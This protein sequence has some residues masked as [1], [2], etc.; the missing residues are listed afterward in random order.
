MRQL[1]PVDPDFYAGRKVVVTGG[2][3]FLGARTASQLEASGAEVAAIGSKDY[4]LTEQTDV[5]RLY[6]E[7][8]PSLV[9]HAAGAIGGIGANV[10]NPGRFVYANALMGLL[11][12]EEARLAEVEKFVLIS[13]TCTYPN[14]APLPMREDSLW[15][16]KPAGATGPYGIA[17]RMLHEASIGYE[18]QYGMDSATLMLSNLYGPGDHFDEETSHVLAALVRRFVE[19]VDSGVATVTNWGTGSPT[20]EFL[21]VDDAARA[22]ALAGSR[23]NDTAPVNIGTGVETSIKE[24]AELIAD[25]AGFTGSIEWDTTKPDGQARRYLDVEKAKAFGFEAQ[26][27]LAEGIAETVAWYREHGAG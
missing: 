25:A 24:L 9:V 16:G 1:Q 23:H 21:H 17:K 26:V 22:I 12:L 19:A 8:Q 27:P 7:Q 20:R 2:T 13:T 14:S 6:E 4:N 3:G 18:A 15:D 5:R 10:A 11:M